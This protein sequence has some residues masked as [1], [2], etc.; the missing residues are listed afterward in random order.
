VAAAFEPKYDHIDRHIRRLEKKIEAGADMVMTQPIFDPR[1]VKQVYNATKHLDFP[2]FLGIMPLAS[3]GN[4]ELLHNEVPGFSI[5]DEVR[6]RMAKVGRGPKARREGVEIAK[7]VADAILEYFNGVYIM[8]PFNRYSMTVAL[9][10]H[11]A[12]N[13]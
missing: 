5:P 13:R 1:Q 12:K 9:T 7:S 6:A 3:A 10:K 2:I 4:A 8:T 11:I